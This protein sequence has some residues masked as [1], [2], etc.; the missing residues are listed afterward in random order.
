ML[1]KRV[2]IRLWRS[3]KILGSRT[4]RKEKGAKVGREAEEEEFLLGINF[5]GT[6]KGK[7]PLRIISPTFS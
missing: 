3:D 7:S 5:A 1:L 6:E 2:K 4:Q